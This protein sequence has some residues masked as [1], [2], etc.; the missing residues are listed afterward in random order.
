MPIKSVMLIEPDDAVRNALTLLLEG[1][2]WQVY[3][4]DHGSE[5]DSLLLDPNL[6]ALVSESVL[7]DRSAGEILRL[8]KNHHLPVLF[9]GHHQQLERAVELMREGASDYLEKPFIQSRLLNTLN[10]LAEQRN[11]LSG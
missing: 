3:S 8:A 11:S 5:M 2:G 9:L 1:Q 10:Q 4:L 6:V 7:P